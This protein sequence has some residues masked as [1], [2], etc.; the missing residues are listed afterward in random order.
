MTMNN[1]V[2]NFMLYM[3]NKWNHSEAMQLFGESL[4]NH[5][6]DKWR[7][8]LSITSDRTMFWYSNLD[9]KCRQTLVDRANQLYNK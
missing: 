5:I 1:E 4:G 2:T 7:E 6:Y 9:V 3:Y 8:A